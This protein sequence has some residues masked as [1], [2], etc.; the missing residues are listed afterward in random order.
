MRRYKDLTPT[1]ILPLEGE[2]KTVPS[3]LKRKVRFTLVELIVVVLVVGLVL[4]VISQI[5]LFSLSS[6]TKGSQRLKLQRDAYYA[7]LMIQ[8]QLRPARV[9][10]VDVPNPYTVYVD[11]STGE[12]FFFDT[13]EKKLFYCKD[14]GSQE[15]IMEGGAGTQF[16]VSRDDGII[17]ITLTLERGNVG[18]TLRTVIKPRN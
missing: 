5:P 8:H 4:L 12:C 17:N 10:D 1:S 11:P 3:S 13:G 18:A 6:W 7:M 2:E 15:L 16:D 14:A 9:S